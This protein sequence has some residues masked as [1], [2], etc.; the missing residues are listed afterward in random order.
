M[1]KNKKS[2]ILYADQKGVF[3]Q[4]PDEYAGK[5][6]KHIFQYVND[7]NPISDDLII[8]I[9]FEPIKQ[10]LKRDLQRWE[11]YID[12]QKLNG[13]KGG[14]PS[15]P[16][17]TQETQAF[18]SEPKKPDSVSVSDSVSDSETDKDIDSNK[19]QTKRFIKPTIEEI[20]TEMLEQ[21]MSDES[22]RFYHYYESNGWMVGRNKM[23]NW[24]A[25]IVTWKKNQKPVQQQ[26]V[27]NQ[28]RVL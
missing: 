7:E 11:D 2:F 10:C 4:L 25:A 1:A 3:E 23:K 16:K 12:K 28:Y 27:Q 20:R 15:K 18:L 14:R 6:I 17:E 5:L 21:K 19:K 13:S 26:P 22:E 24:R 8:N 9:A